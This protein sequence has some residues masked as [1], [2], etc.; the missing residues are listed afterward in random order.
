MISKKAFNTICV[1]LFF[2]LT[3]LL[4]GPLCIYLN[5][6][7]EFSFLLSDVWFILLGIALVCIIFLTLIIFLIKNS[8]HKS[9]ISLL[10]SIAL[11]LWLQGNILVWDYGVLDGKEINWDNY[12][13][14][15]F[16]DSVAWVLFLSV[17]FKKRVY[18][19]K[20]AAKLSIALILIQTFTLFLTWFQNPDQP[21]WKKY[22]INGEQI[23]NFSS[24]KNVIILVL[25]TY[26]SDI[27]QELI[28]EHHDYLDIFKGFTYYR[29]SIGGFPTTY[30]S[31]PLILTGSYYDNS[32]TMQEYIKKSYLNQSVPLVLK[33]N[34]FL[35][36]LF[37]NVKQT[38]YYNDEIASNFIMA[39]GSNN[40]KQSLKKIYY[41]T[42]YRFSP[43]YIKEHIFFKFNYYINNE[44][45][46]VDF[47]LD[48]LDFANNIECNSEVNIEKSV[49]KFYHLRGTHPPFNLN[50]RLEKVNLNY[51]R[52]GYKVQARASLEIIN[53]FLNALRNNGV[54]DNSM[55]F[56]VG[57]HGLGSFG[58]NVQV[59]G[60]FQDNID[61][62]LK[63]LTSNNIIASGIPLILVKPFNSIQSMRISDAPVC[64]ADIPKTIFTEL[65]IVNDFPGISMFDI[66]E[67]EVRERR[68][69][70]YNWEHEYWDKQFLPAM[71][72]YIINGF[73]WLPQSWS[74]TYRKFTF[75]GASNIE[76]PTYQ[77]ES[78]IKFGIGGNAEQYQG[79]GWST[80]E[81]DFTWTVE[82]NAS[83][84]ISINQP[85]S[86]L[87]LKASLSPFISD[88]RDRQRVNIYIN[89][90]KLG[91]WVMTDSGEYS[92]TLPKDFITDSS[93]KITFELPDAISPLELKIS[94]DSRVLGIA[95]HSIIISE[96]KQL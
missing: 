47:I 6:V 52:D 39:N 85:Q 44:I 83:L 72:E 38:I 67:S 71:Q 32:I 25:D 68:Y 22:S 76:P 93:L 30:P 37:P 50:E 51:N 36:D 81:K 40:K 29:N 70:S 28:N 82:E 8:F 26:Q 75:E 17:A 34:G 49:F 45:K 21:D 89:G 69:L 86:D 58:V 5:N 16:I 91:E 95:M 80:P 23:Y 53:R 46:E 33:Q 65:K 56:I 55:I 41:I 78:Q 73:S 90:N 27:F 92:F 12:K 88:K 61:K 64:L 48:D 84:D 31:V 20:V 59:S 13:I 63:G 57:D 2:S 54:Y 18:I 7:N 35:V 79:D 11:M 24:K 74:P 14:Y 19:Y 62:G 66:S 9:I 60:Y 94:E 77:Y 4:F 87:V 43:Q 1:V 3:T 10:F 96:K 15:G 42:L